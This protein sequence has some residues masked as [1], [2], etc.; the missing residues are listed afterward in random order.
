MSP[1]DMGAVET[2]LEN[3]T[4]RVEEDSLQAL[5]ALKGVKPREVAGLLPNDASKVDGL[6]ELAQF[7]GKNMPGVR[8]T[9]WELH[10]AAYCARTGI[11]QQRGR[12]Y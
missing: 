9:L 4:K 8:E 12:R 3:H 10:S 11:K 7:C 2:I 1:I 6:I 5:G